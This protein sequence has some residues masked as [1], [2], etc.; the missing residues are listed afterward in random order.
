MAKAG[1]YSQKRKK[2]KKSICIL[3]LLLILLIG[4]FSYYTKMNRNDETEAGVTEPETIEQD[5]AVQQATVV[6]EQLLPTEQ[7][8]EPTDNTNAP[9]IETTVIETT[10]TEPVT[11][12]IQ[13]SQSEVG[14]ISENIPE[15]YSS[16]LQ[17]YRELIMMDSS[18]F[19]ELYGNESELDLQLS[20]EALEELADKGELASIAEILGRPKLSERYPHVKGGTLYYAKLYKD[21]ESFDPSVY[22]Y[23]Y[24]NID[25]KHSDELLIGTYDDYHDDYTILAIYTGKLD[26]PSDLTIMSV[27]DNSRQHLRIYTDGTICLDSS[28]GASLHYWYYYRIDG[29]YMYDMFETIASFHIN[30]DAPRTE[31]MVEAVETYEAMLTPVENIVWQ[32]LITG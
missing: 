19:L 25:G 2:N 21:K 1:R 10:V 27:P 17:Q 4:L 18:E 23:A 5:Q 3:I 13:E 30:Y 15:G 8:S 6:K 12:P 11:E 24:Y 14:M 9:E 31:Y 22:Y 7:T 26:A 20:I 32:Q 29:E 28:G 16:V